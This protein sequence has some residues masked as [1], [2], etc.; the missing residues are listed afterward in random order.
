MTAFVRSSTIRRKLLARTL[1]NAAS[2]SLVS[3]RIRWD[4]YKPAIA[5]FVAEVTTSKNKSV[6]EFCADYI[7]LAMEQWNGLDKDM[8]SLERAI[9]SG[10]EDASPKVRETSRSSYLVFI[11]RY[12]HRAEAIKSVSE[13]DH[14]C[15]RKCI[16]PA[17]IDQIN[18]CVWDEMN[19][20]CDR[21]RWPSS[22][23]RKT[24]L[25]RRCESA[26]K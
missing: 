21:L 24:S 18:I 5:L 11:T 4:R 26:R 10:L 15:F 23:K 19:R 22:R 7:K 6:R 16:P 20:L 1:A 25:T 9:I 8:D 12:P 3:H 13:T 2:L 17:Q 14:F